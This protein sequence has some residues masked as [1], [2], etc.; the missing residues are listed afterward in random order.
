[1]ATGK[2]IRRA[3]AL[4]AGAADD[5]DLLGG[6]LFSARPPTNHVGWLAVSEQ[7]C[8]PGVGRVLMNEAMRRFM[9]GPRA[10]WK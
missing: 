3:T 7:A 2:H 10:S 9:P 1:V 6:L 5:T 4:V 8:G